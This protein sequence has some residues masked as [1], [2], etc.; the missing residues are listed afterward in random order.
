MALRCQ[1]GPPIKTGP[2]LGSGLWL[3]YIVPKKKAGDEKTGGWAQ[4][5][6]DFL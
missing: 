6:A 5:E 2:A 3:P 4:V 1:N